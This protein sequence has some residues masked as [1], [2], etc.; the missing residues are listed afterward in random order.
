MRD[1]TV[2]VMNDVA[3]QILGLKRRPS[4]IGKP[5][6]EVLKSQQEVCRIVAERLRAVAPAEPRRAAVEE[7]RQGD[8]LHAVAGPRRAAGNVT[9]AALFFKDLT[10]VEQL[11]ERER[12]RDRLAALGEMAAAIAHE[13]KN[14]LAGIEVMAG[15]P[16]AA[17]GRLRRM[18]SR[19]SATSS[20]KPRWP[21]P[22]SSRCS[23]SCGRSGCRSSA[24]RST[25]AIRDAVSMAES[26]V[27][28]GNVK[29]TVEFAGAAAGD[30]G[31][32]APAAADLHEPADQRLRGARRRRGGAA[33]SP[34]R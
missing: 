23:T 22:S 6:T 24:S 18:R 7:H 13:V 31:R 29:V 32:P 16:Q 30:S 17:A 10:R 12:L 21:T 5:F 19:S 4:D 8:W 34:R 26:H 27:P 15:T 3:Y 2:T 11:E 9:G 28:R 14:P 1:G 33:S 25:D 20:R